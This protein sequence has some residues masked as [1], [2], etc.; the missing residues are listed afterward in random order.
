MVVTQG[1]GFSAGLAR[2]FRRL[3]RPSWLGGHVC[4]EGKESEADGKKKVILATVWEPPVKGVTFL[5]WTYFQVQLQRTTPKM[6]APSSRTASRRRSHT[7]AT[8]K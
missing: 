4:G 5:F 8:S 2:R 7:T 6:P 3:C 1:E